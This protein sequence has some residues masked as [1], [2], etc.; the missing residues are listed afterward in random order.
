MY[1][2]IY[3]YIYNTLPGAI[4]MI[5]VIQ[6]LHFE[7]FWHLESACPNMATSGFHMENVTRSNGLGCRRPGELDCS[8]GAAWRWRP[9][10]FWACPLFQLLDS[11]WFKP[12]PH[13]FPVVI[14][15][16]VYSFDPA[17]DGHG[18][19]VSIAVSLLSLGEGWHDY[20]H[21]FP[22]DYAAA[23]PQ[24]QTGKKKGT[25]FWAQLVGP[26]TWD[27]DAAIPTIFINIQ[28]IAIHCTCTHT[29]VH[30]IYTK[31]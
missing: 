19:R 4:L 29:H 23:A 13:G 2:Y 18:P 24:L 8:W 10:V 20:H 15:P 28:G 30:I 9:L 21:L 1:V 22:W 25:G 27:T 14:F 26:A 16:E 3:I 31:T 6:S 11:R 7:S 17:A 12:V 5:I